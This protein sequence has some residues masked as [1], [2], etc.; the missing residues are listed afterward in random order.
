MAESRPAI[1]HS[2]KRKAWA[3]VLGVVL[4]LVVFAHMGEGAAAPQ[5]SSALAAADKA[6]AAGKFKAAASAYSRLLGKG[7]GLSSREMAR[8]LM[9]RGIAYRN[10]G[11]PS[12]AI[13]DLTAALWLK[14]LTA[15]E[16]QRARD[17][18][19]QAYRSAGI[20]PPGGLARRQVASP[21]LGVGHQKKKAGK[22]APKSSVAAIPAFATQVRPSRAATAPTRATSR[23]EGTPKRPQTA[24]RPVTPKPKT[25]PKKLPAFATEVEPAAAKSQAPAANGLTGF[26]SS[27]FAPNTPSP[28]NAT[29]GTSQAS[30]G[31]GGNRKKPITSQK[32]P[33]APVLTD[34]SKVTTVHK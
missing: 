13:A 23:R 26:F 5:K 17:N 28:E 21:K 9:R 14:G 29:G 31:T 7:E 24:R 34:W 32:T 11:R 4:S 20:T 30:S 6:F 33:P 19:A 10:L 8:I 16:R 27:L 18:L 3:V 25:P 22:S 2:E 12:R 15:A 1:W